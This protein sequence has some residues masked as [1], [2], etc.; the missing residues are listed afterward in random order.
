MADQISWIFEARVKPGK[1]AELEEA[2]AGLVQ[3]ADGEPGTLGYQWS[4]DE[5]GGAAVREHYADSAAALAHLQGFKRDWLERM[6]TLVDPIG[7]TVW[8]D[9][10][11]ELRTE[12]GEGT[13][14]HT[15]L[16]GFAR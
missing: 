7:T 10:S 14:F 16:G 3:V 8:G 4:I 6:L 11:P 12:L 9:V 15:E 5:D 2:I 13:S 1:R